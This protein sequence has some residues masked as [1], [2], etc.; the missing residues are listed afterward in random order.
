MQFLGVFIKPYR[1]FIRKRCKTNFYKKIEFWNTKMQVSNSKLN[2]EEKIL[3]RANIN[4]Y[5]GLLKH[6]NTYKLRKKLIVDKLD[7]TFISYFNIPDNLEKVIT[8][9]LQ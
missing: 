6:Y 5:L 9:H 1:V 7:K 8:R 2:S 3:F 4:S